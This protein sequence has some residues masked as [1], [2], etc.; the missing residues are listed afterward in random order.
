MFLFPL[1]SVT[2]RSTFL[3]L[4]CVR[5]MNGTSCSLSGRRGTR[6]LRFVWRD[7]LGLD[8]ISLGAYRPHQLFSDPYVSAVVFSLSQKSLFHLAEDVLG[9]G[10]SV[11]PSNAWG[12]AGLELPWSLEFA[13]LCWVA[14]LLNA[15][16]CN[17]D[18]PGRAAEAN[19][20]CSKIES[21]V[22]LLLNQSHGVLKYSLKLFFRQ[23]QWNLISGIHQLIHQSL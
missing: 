12:L 3:W 5:N 13:T 11:S 23:N 1:K 4:F 8:N 7:R 14:S 9:G 18:R 6:T 15:V 16:Q 19:K 17:R 21:F 10:R 22:F 2:M 20:C